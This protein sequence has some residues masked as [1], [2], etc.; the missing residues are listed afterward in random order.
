MIDNSQKTNCHLGGYIGYVNRT[1]NAVEINFDAYVPTSGDSVPCSVGG[2]YSNTGYAKTRIVYGGLIGAISA[3]TSHAVKATININKVKV[4]GLTITSAT[5]ASDT[6]GAAGLLGYAWHDTNVNINMLD[7]GSTGTVSS[8]VSG[9]TNAAGLVYNATGHWVVKNI[10]NYNATINTASGGNL[11]LLVTRGINEAEVSAE[12]DI[13]KDALSALYLEVLDQRTNT[14]DSIE[15]NFAIGN[16]SVTNASGVFDEIVAFTHKVGGDITVNGENAVVSINT[17]GSGTALIMTGT[18]CNTYQN[19]TSFGS[20]KVNAHSRYYYNLDYLRTKESPTDAEKFLLWSVKAYA[21]SKIAANN[22]TGTYSLGSNASLDMNGLSYYTI[23]YASISDLSKVTV[24]KFYN[25]EI[26][27]GEAVSSTNTDNAVRSTTNTSPQSQHYMMHCG[28]FRNAVANITLGSLTVQGNVGVYNGNSGFIISGVLGGSSTTASKLINT[29]LTLDGAYIHKKG[30][31]EGGSYSDLNIAAGDNLP[32][33][34]NNVEKNTTLNIKGVRSKGY[35]SLTTGSWYAASSLIGKVGKDDGSDTGINV[36]F[37]D[38]ALDARKTVDAVA[39]PHKTRFNTVYGSTRTIFSNATLLHHYFYSGSGSTGTYNYTQSA[40]WGTSGTAANAAPHLVTYGQEIINTIDHRDTSSPSK[41]EQN[42]Y[43][44]SDYYTSPVS[45]NN[46]E[47]QY[48]AFTTGFLPYVYDIGTLSGAAGSNTDFKHELR[49][50]ISV[51]H[52]NVGC[53]TYNDPYILSTTKQVETLATLINTPDSFAATDFIINLPVDGVSG[54]LQWC[55]NCELEEGETSVDHYPC[56][57]SGTNFVNTTAGYSQTKANVSQYLAGAYY[58]VSTDLTLGGAS[59]VFGTSSTNAFHGVIVGKKQDDESYPTITLSTGHALIDTSDGCVIKNLNF[60]KGQ[61]K[62]DPQPTKAEFKYG[63]DCKVYG[64]IINQIMGGDNIIDNVGITFADTP[65]SETTGSYNHTIPIGGY[66]GVI[67][68]G[69]LFFRNMDGSAANNKGITSFAADGQKKYLYRNPIIGRVLNGYAVCEDFDSD[70]TLLDNGDKNYYISKLDSTITD[71]L[72]VTSSA[73]TA[74][75]AQSWFVLSLLVNSGT[76]SDKTL[77]INSNHKSSHRGTYEN[78]GCMNTM[79]KADS[80]DENETRETVCDKDMFA[81]SAEAETGNVKPY[82]M[83]NYTTDGAETPSSGVWLNT[84]TGYDITMNDDEMDAEDKVWTLDKAY[85]GIGGFN[86]YDSGESN[87]S[88]S[89]DTVDGSISKNCN[90]TCNIK[91]K[92]LTANS[93]EIVL[94]MQFKSYRHFEAKNENKAQFVASL[95]NYTTLDSGFGLFNTFIAS[96]ALTITGLTVSGSVFSDYYSEED[97][98][99]YSNYG[100]VALWP[101][102]YGAT[103]SQSK[104]LSCGLFAGRKNDSNQLKLKNCTINIETSGDGIHSGKN[105]GGFIGSAKAV[106]LQTC[107]AQNVKIFGRFDT[108]GLLGYADGCTITGKI[109]GSEAKSTVTIDS[110]IQQMR[111][112][113]LNED[114]KRY[115][116]CGGLVGR[117]AGS[118]TIDYISV[119]KAAGKTGLISYDNRMIKAGKVVGSD[120]STYMGGIVGCGNSGSTITI[121]NCEVNALSI[122]ARCEAAG[123]VAGGGVNTYIITNVDIDG[124]GT[125]TINSCGKEPI[126]GII[127]Y[128][129]KESTIENVRLYNYSLHKDLPENMT[130]IQSDYYSKTGDNYYQTSQNSIGIAIGGTLTKVNIKNLFVSDC[131]VSGECCKKV[132]GICGYNKSQEIDGYNIAIKN[133]T[134]NMVNTNSYSNTSYAG[135]LVGTGGVGNLK[136]VGFYRNDTP[137]DK[138][139]AGAAFTT[140]A[141]STTKYIIFSDYTGEGIPVKQENS[142]T[143][144]SGAGHTPKVNNADVTMP[145]STSVPYATSNP[146]VEMQG[147][148]LYTGDG[149]AATVAG[150]PVQS[151]IEGMDATSDIP[152]NKYTVTTAETNFKKYYPSCL[153]TFKTEWSESGLGNDFKDFAVLIVEDNLRA[154]TTEMI[155]SYLELLTN[156]NYTFGK[157][158]SGVHSMTISKMSYDS[159]AGRF[160]KQSGSANL[161][162]DTSTGQFYMQTTVDTAETDSAG[163]PKPTFTLIDVSFNDPTGGSTPVYHLYVPVIVKKMIDVDFELATGSGTQFD[164]QWYV[165][166]SRYADGA[167][168]AENIGSVGTLRFTYTYKR[169][170]KEWQEAL[171]YGE[172]FMT[173]YSKALTLT[174]A[175]ESTLLSDFPSAT[176]L[177]LVDTNPG[178]YGKEYYSTI[179]TAYSTS[180]RKLTLNST[181][182]TNGSDSFSPVKICDLLNITAE[183]KTGSDCHYDSCA[184]A[185]ATVK[186]NLNGT[187]TY[188]KKVADGTGH[189]KLTVVNKIGESTAL[190]DSADLNI[191]ESYYLSF[192]TKFDNEVDNPETTSVDERATA[193]HYYTVTA[194]RLE[195]GSSPAKFTSAKQNKSIL[196][197]NIFTQSDVKYYT[198]KVGDLDPEEINSINDSVHVHLETTVNTTDQAATLFGAQLA[199]IDMYQ[200]FLVY[201]TNSENSKRAV[202]GE[203]TVSALMK[204]SSVNNPSSVTEYS[205]NTARRGLDYVEVHTNSSITTKVNDGGAI[206]K[207]DLTISYPNQGQREAQFPSR[208]G[209][210]TSEDNTKYATVSAFSKLGFDNERT[211][212]STTQ[213]TAVLKTGTDTVDDNVR[214]CKNY[215]YYIISRK[216]PELDYYAYA[217][218]DGRP[219]GQLGINANDLPDNTGKVTVKT[220]AD[221]DVRP[222]ASTVSDY[223]YV[224]LTF[225]LQQK[226]QGS[227]SFNTTLYEGLDTGKTIDDYLYDVHIALNDSSGQIV[228]TTSGNS[229]T[230]V[231]PRSLVTALDGKT[232]GSTEYMKIPITF[233]VF[234]GNL[235]PKNA[236]GEPL[237]NGETAISS[238]EAKNLRYANYKIEVKAQMM[239]IDTVTGLPV[240]EALASHDLIYTNA[241]LQV[242]YIK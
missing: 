232:N 27:D 141:N 49:V 36:T 225:T 223:D 118:M 138:M 85:R 9:G 168:L 20:G 203:P 88:A 169:T 38:I 235:P 236:N 11:G 221:Y 50:N 5:S 130:T 79:L 184:E 32:L 210:N 77:Y 154:P 196:F 96:Q 99:I 64:G 105:C 207:A 166:N 216:D 39:D 162:R 40:D 165:D 176:K 167:M 132:G 177:V 123:A 181:T 155:D 178:R 142:T 180:T 147:G 87:F 14:G 220:A 160:V 113:N 35:S 63:G 222:V 140:A 151:I 136:I 158:L 60:V 229:Y 199:Y 66:V 133:I 204:V 101:R 97:G 100:G 72:T 19:K 91:V 47:S 128:V 80:S 198:Y 106:S 190:S 81:S 175:S 120:D 23:N 124:K 197:A 152:K 172:N 52:L 84:F 226:K 6:D 239:K 119:T 121:D 103:I 156:T 159:T 195:N 145:G 4:D 219:Y 135:D 231:I 186:A 3:G 21:N 163:N 75:N 68:N 108:G 238:F 187:M 230:F 13:S 90:G 134:S 82:L 185:Q 28:L 174:P 193:I 157:N 137:T 242:D 45:S 194:D 69:G 164:S 104:R 89:T 179:G 34:I 125:A 122:D 62:I 71:K 213:E 29:A 102:K 234:T 201:L 31:P 37:S 86:A 70:A 153:S 211:A 98:E 218:D 56:S 115:T 94:D 54:N 173:N 59:Q 144:T 217:S 1:T 214:D 76:L 16:A 93:T 58:I 206:I 188:F 2:S 7:I 161:G 117:T 110:I 241:K 30:T 228:K 215:Q 17:D 212:L 208:S 202:L 48:D 65:I 146:A 148:D 192:Y 183:V 24:L 53:G 112:T 233:D 200:S 182:F 42:K 205:T 92:S 73:I 83:T 126:G 189:Y 127:G 114:N 74:K 131:T 171:N 107:T 237:M 143:F 150:L 33:L 116:G 78:V 57:L 25:K 10:A 12:G 8:T 44:G 139:I 95:D 67:L 149:M 191:K 227:E 43:Y 46:D 22:F 26:E 41:S 129:R 240:L 51:T 109:T 170:K 224:M 55:D 111:G 209:N 18:S 15:K 61:I